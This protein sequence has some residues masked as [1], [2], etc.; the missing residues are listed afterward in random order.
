M[1]CLSAARSNGSP[2]TTTTS[3]R[4]PG[5][6]SRSGLL[7]AEHPAEAI[8]LLEDAPSRAPDAAYALELRRA[9]AAA[10]LYAGEYTRAAPLFDAVGSDYR[11]YLPAADP[12]VLDCACHAGQAYAETGKPDKALPQL[13]Y[14]VQNAD[15]GLDADEAEKVIDSRFLVAQMLAAS[16]DPDAAGA[17]LAALRPLL[18]SAFGE[19]ST[20]VRN[21]DKQVSRLRAPGSYPMPDLRERSAPRR[22]RCLRGRP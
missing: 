11:R 10:L 14:Y 2:A 17:E 8:S 18:A 22:A 5:L 9:L 3:A 1:F 12:L 13:R 16:D 6:A 21:L 15:P 7:Q 20:Q 4:L 19:N